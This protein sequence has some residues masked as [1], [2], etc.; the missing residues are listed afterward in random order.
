MW[1]YDVRDRD[2]FYL[3]VQFLDV[4]FIPWKFEIDTESHGWRNVIQRLEIPAEVAFALA[5]L[6][7]KIL[8]SCTVADG[9][10]HKAPCVANIHTTGTTVLERYQNISK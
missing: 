5:V 8:N 1:Y 7:A 4:W 3:H 6:A 10:I 9:E 2:V